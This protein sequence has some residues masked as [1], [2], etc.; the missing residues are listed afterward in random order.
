M[1]KKCD[2]IEGNLCKACEREHQEVMD[3]V[4]A[5][6]GWWPMV[7][8]PARSINIASTLNEAP[9]EMIYV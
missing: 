9:R 5:A 3:E 2:D 4:I 8:A 1:C 7:V 6:D